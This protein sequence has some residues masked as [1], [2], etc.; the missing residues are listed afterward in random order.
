MRQEKV[1]LDGMVPED[2]CD[3]CPHSSCGWI[4]AGLHGARDWRSLMLEL[5]SLRASILSQIQ[6]QEIESLRGSTG[7][8]SSWPPERRASRQEA[9]EDGNTDRISPGQRSLTH[10]STCIT[11]PE[12]LRRFRNALC[13]R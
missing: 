13:G 8:K 7:S 12:K 11:A 9:G 5:R 10:L 4:T 6:V 3:S 1:A 2:M